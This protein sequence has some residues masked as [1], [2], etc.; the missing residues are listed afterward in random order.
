MGSVANPRCLLPASSIVTL[1]SLEFP[2]IPEA[3][4]HFRDIDA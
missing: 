1:N 2:K 4:P 3:H